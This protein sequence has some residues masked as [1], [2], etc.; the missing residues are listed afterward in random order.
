MD[1]LEKRS[2]WLIRWHLA[3]QAPIFVPRRLQDPGIRKFIHYLTVE[4]WRA[5]V[6]VRNWLLAD[7]TEALSLR[8]LFIAMTSVYIGRDGSPYPTVSN[9]AFRN[10]LGQSPKQVLRG[11]S[12]FQQGQGDI[13]RSIQILANAILDAEACITVH[14][15]RDGLP[16]R[17]PAFAVAAP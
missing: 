17:R 13:S 14:R 12:T 1:L 3:K 8:N 7:N 5:F 16:T 4:D 11:L 2:H 15:V 6:L 10:H 9:L